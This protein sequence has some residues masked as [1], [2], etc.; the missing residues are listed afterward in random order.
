MTPVACCFCLLTA[1]WGPWSSASG[2]EKPMSAKFLK[3]P[4]FNHTETQTQSNREAQTTKNLPV[5]CCLDPGIC[6]ALIERKHFSTPI[7]HS[8]ATASKQKGSK[9]LEGLT[10]SSRTYRLRYRSKQSH[11]QLMCHKVIFCKSMH[12]LH[13][14]SDLCTHNC[15]RCMSRE[16]I[17]SSNSPLLLIQVGMYSAKNLCHLQSS[18][19]SHQVHTHLFPPGSP[20]AMAE[21]LK[22]CHTISHRILC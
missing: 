22:C 16:G 9:H 17:T 19:H 18:A 14:M 6:F 8:F 15:V 7:H 20:L 3:E 1:L 10:S 2:I 12:I 11:Q 4:Y 5:C 21:A 13:L